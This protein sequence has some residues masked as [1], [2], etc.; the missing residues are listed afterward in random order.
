MDAPARPFEHEDESANTR[1]R[2]GYD[3]RRCCARASIADENCEA[4]AGGER[5]RRAARRPGRAD[6]EI[7]H[8]SFHNGV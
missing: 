3:P 4:G 6:A 1:I 7:S 8:T 2:S 5:G